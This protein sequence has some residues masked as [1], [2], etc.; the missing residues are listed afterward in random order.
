[1]IENKHYTVKEITE[2][3]NVDEKTV[4]RWINEGKLFAVHLAGTTVRVPKSEL[5]HFYRQSQ[6]R[7]WKE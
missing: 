2:M 3:F 4:R 6:A 5:Q 1:M 7:G